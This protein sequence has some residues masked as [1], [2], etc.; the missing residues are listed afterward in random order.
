[1]EKELPYE[2]FTINDFL[3]D[4]YFQDWI[5]NPSTETNQFWEEWLLQH[6][7]KADLVNT[8]KKILSDLDFKVNRPAPGKAQASLE[9]ALAIID[10]MERAHTKRSV[11]VRFNQL[12]RVA[13]ILVVGLGLFAYFINNWT[14]TK[15]ITT[16]YGQLDTI[17]LPDQST[18]ILNA[19][20]NIRYDKKW[21]AGKP[22]E[23]WLK[24]EAF[25]DVKHIDT[26]KNIE[27]HEHFIVHL[28]KID[29][30]VLGT[31]FNIRER[32]G[33]IEV[34][35]Q[36]GAIKV[37]FTDKSRSDVVMKPG[38]MMII[39][40]KTSEQV[41]STTIDPTDYTAWK[42]KRL[43]LRNPTLKEITNYLEDVYGKKII[44]SSTQLANKHVNGPILI[45]SL[46]D[47]LFVISTVLNVDITTKGNT[48]FVTQ[49]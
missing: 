7:E 49:K 8:A 34:V 24:G 9:K 39:D 15:E 26:D 29:V 2:N 48:I 37:L 12:W 44:I 17:L 25:F 14:D 32:R 42:T 19:N 43:V 1:M 13:A 10:A 23:L 3:T 40:V 11:L 47:A 20:S 35:L 33:R 6:P 27:P 46:N 5:I 22:R 21:D 16:I 41:V 4:A 45:D 30:E 31:Q 18:V 28:D 38:D 36:Q